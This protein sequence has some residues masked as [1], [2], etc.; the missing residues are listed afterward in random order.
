M[1]AFFR[2]FTWHANKTAFFTKMLFVYLSTISCHHLLLRFTCP[3]GTK[4]PR[5][6]TQSCTTNV[7]RSCLCVLVFG[8]VSE[9]CVKTHVFMKRTFVSFQMH[10]GPYHEM[11]R[12]YRVTCIL[13]TINPQHCFGSTFTNTSTTLILKTELNWYGANVFES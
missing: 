4:S 3:L 11:G 6:P 5:W 9:N 7:R 8:R 12:L 13:V 10:F 2:Y 1:C